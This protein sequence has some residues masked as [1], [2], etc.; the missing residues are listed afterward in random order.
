MKE[1][2]E[3]VERRF[4]ENQLT[5]EEG[6]HD[7]SGSCGLI[8]V[9]VED[10]CYISNIGDSRAVIS[11]N[12]GKIRQAVTRDHKPSDELERT[13]VLNAGGRVYQYDLFP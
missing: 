9:V 5:S 6:K 12:G 10:T 8:M 11:R 13:R 4:I 1:A 7:T 3:A 2:C